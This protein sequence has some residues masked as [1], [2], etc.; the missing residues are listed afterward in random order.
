MQKR[1]IVLMLVRWSG[2]EGGREREME[3][4][5]DRDKESERGR[6]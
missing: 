5:R 3:R 6:K 4:D 1:R 2:R